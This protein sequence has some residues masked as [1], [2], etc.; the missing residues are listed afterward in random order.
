MKQYPGIDVVSSNQYG[1]ADVEVA[2]V[3]KDKFGYPV[4]YVLRNR[5]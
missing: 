1:G 4:F 5:G 2:Y 3:V